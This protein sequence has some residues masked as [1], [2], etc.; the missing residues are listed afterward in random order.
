MEFWLLG[1]G[2]VVHSFWETFLKPLMSLL[3]PN[4]TVEIGCE[5]GEVTKELL[6]CCLIQGGT[7]HGIDPAPGFDSDYW[8]QKADGRFVFHRTISL[9]VLSTIH[10]PD[11]VLIDGDHNWFTVYH[12]LKVLQETAT[13][14]GRPFPVVVLHDI[15]WPY[16]RRDMYYNPQTIPP[17][18]LHPFG[19]LGLIPGVREAHPQFGMNVH[20]NNALQENTPRNGV[21]TAV[22]DFLRETDLRMDFVQ[23]P[24][25]HGLGVLIPEQTREVNPAVANLIDSWKVGDGLRLHLEALEKAR[26]GDT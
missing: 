15:G 26:L 24:G 19:Q 20:L 7:L 22:E 5:S 10:E 25:F 21:L 9:N 6:V 2:R 16:G 11:F 18:F 3:R 14:S 13:N 1:K 23:V 8:V 4:C 17:E 12:E